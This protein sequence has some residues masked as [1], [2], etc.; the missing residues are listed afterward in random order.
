M[1]KRRFLPG[2]VVVLASSLAVLAYQDGYCPSYPAAERADFQRALDADLKYASYMK[3][4]EPG[5]TVHAQTNAPIRNVVDQLVFTKM[6]RDGVE[7]SGLSTDA[8]FVRRIYVDLTGRIPTYDQARAFLTSATPDRSVL[9]EQLLNS[10]AYTDQLSH[11][12]LDRFQVRLGQD[13]GFIGI[14]ARNNFYNYIRDFVQK[15]RPYNK[16]VQEML[17]ATGDPDEVAALPLLARQ[18]ENFYDSANQDF[19]DD[20]TDM[21]TTEFLGFKTEC[22]SCHDGRRHLEKINL[23]LTPHTRRDFWR[24]S[25]FF[26]RTRVQYV[27][28]DL[29]GYR[30]RLIF[31]NAKSGQYTAAIDPS[32]PGPRP[33]RS[34]ANE[35]PYF[36]ISGQAPASEAWRDEFARLLTT[37]RQFARAAVNYLWAYMMGSGIVDPPNGWDLERIDPTVQ[38]PEGWP[39][40]NSQPELLDALTDAFIQSNYSTKAIIRLIAQSSTYQLSSVY[41]AGKWQD[42]YGRYYARYEARRMGPEQIFDSITTATKTEPSMSV[43]G[44]P[45]L[46]HYSNQLPHPYAS[47]DWDTENFLENLGRG[48]YRTRRNLTRLPLIG[49]LDLLNRWTVQTRTQGFPDSYSPPTQLQGWM[50]EGLSDQEIIRRIFLA[51]LTRYPTT[52]ELEIITSKPNANRQIWLDGVQWALI[53]K[54]DFLFKH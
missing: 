21:A 36:F 17:T 25:A 8:E 23:F 24:L 50:S 14:S 26:S 42:G 52:Q 16:V 18:I 32:H 40:Q 9:I 5:K 10:P 45:D 54:S 41:P 43:P 53:Q 28:D 4:L 49:L 44:L 6:A 33:S 48:D 3:T 34:T 30:P 19:W 13:A 27:N 35:L 20:F 12:F 47:T 39:L 51:T 31:S 46:F 1:L 37:D 22:I 2:L 7:S 29:A 15:D 11:Y 38:L